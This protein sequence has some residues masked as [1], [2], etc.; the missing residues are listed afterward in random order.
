M[1]PGRGMRC[2]EG[3]ENGEGLS[4]FGRTSL[5][6]R[7]HTPRRLPLLGRAQIGTSPEAGGELGR[8]RGRLSV[9][10]AE[11]PADHLEGTAGP[12]VRVAKCELAGLDWL[13]ANR[14]IEAHRRQ[15]ESRAREIR[16]AAA[17]F[18]ALTW[19][20]RVPGHHRALTSAPAGLANPLTILR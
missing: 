4:P 3:G 2:S 14:P 8:R 12:Q 16:R 1:L 19:T 11:P 7:R 9:P 17:L 5:F 13:G 18:S 15:S 10:V 20:R 6:R